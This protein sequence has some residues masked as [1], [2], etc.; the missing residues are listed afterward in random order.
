MGLSFMLTCLSSFPQPG[1]STSTFKGIVFAALIMLIFG[2]I[3]DFKELSILAK[4]VIQ[5]IAS[6]VLINFGIRTQMVYIGNT[7]NIIITYIW[8]IG[9]TNAFN[10]LD[11]M[12]G[13]AAGTAL[14]VNLS[15]LVAFLLTNCNEITFLS[16]A[17]MGAIISFLIFNRPPAKIYMGNAGS[18]FLGFILSAIVLSISFAPLERKL[19]LLSPLLILGLPIFDTA[20]LILMRIKRGKLPFEKSNDHI[21][22]RLLAQGYSKKKTLFA[23]LSLC[24]FFSSCGIL[25][26]RVSN[27]FS[28]IIVVL[29]ILVSLII[30]YGLSKVAINE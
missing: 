18:H 25:V 17:L 20:F 10:H 21:A 26:S 14:I 3:D 29:V 9:I 4:L 28:L 15:L 30:T 16:L 13:L 2:I 8:V 27:I 23:V 1:I 11:I 12:D 6:T 5:I 7:L 24:I 22:L 19:A